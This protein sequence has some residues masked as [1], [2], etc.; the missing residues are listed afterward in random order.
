MGQLAAKFAAWRSETSGA[1][2]VEYCLIAGLIALTIITGVS[3]V[4][5]STQG[6]FNAAVNAWPEQ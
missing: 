3:A 2:A 4:G 6:N 5:S 1:T